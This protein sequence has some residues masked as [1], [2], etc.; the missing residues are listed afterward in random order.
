ARDRELRPTPAG[1][2]RV[3]LPCCLGDCGTEPGRR[4]RG[5]HPRPTPLA[6]DFCRGSKAG[7]RPFMIRAIVFKELREIA[8]IAAVAVA[9]YLAFLSQKIG[10]FGFFSWVPG[11]NSDGKPDLPFVQDWAFSS[12]FIWF[13]ILAVAL[14]LRQS[15]W[16]PHQ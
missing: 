8:G 15:A 16:E 10:N 3:A 9:V 12:I 14:G 11:F 6:A 7:E 4:V 2:D 1:S 5:L 13:A